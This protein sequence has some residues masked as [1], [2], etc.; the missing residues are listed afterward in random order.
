MM[1]VSVWIRLHVCKTEVKKTKNEQTGQS[2]VKYCEIYVMFMFLLL[3]KRSFFSAQK[4]AIPEQ[5]E[6]VFVLWS[7]VYGIF[8][9]RL[10]LNDD[11]AFDKL[12]SFMLIKL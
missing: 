12:L 3:F 8:F 2:S 5:L 9:Y 4:C 7:F 6:Y 1:D 10:L 11:Y